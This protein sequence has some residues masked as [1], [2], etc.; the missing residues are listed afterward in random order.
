MEN[1]YIQYMNKIINNTIVIK[2]IHSSYLLSLLQQYIKEKRNTTTTPTIKVS[3]YFNEIKIVLQFNIDY[4]AKYDE[5]IIEI[6]KLLKDNIS[7]IE[8]DIYNTITARKS[9]V[10]TILNLKDKLS[11]INETIPINIIID[12]NVDD[13]N[14]SDSSDDDNSSSSSS[15][16]ED[17]GDIYEINTEERINRDY[18][19]SFHNKVNHHYKERVLNFNVYENDEDDYYKITDRLKSRDSFKFYHYDD[20]DVDI[21]YGVKKIRPS[22]YLDPP[23][24]VIYLDYPYIDDFGNLP[25]RLKFLSL[26]TSLNQKLDLGTPSSLSHLEIR[27]LNHWLTYKGTLSRSITHLRLNCDYIIRSI[28]NKMTKPLFLIPTSV[29]CISIDY[30]YIHFFKMVDEIEYFNGY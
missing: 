19:N 13:D 22:Q 28:E 25:P 11:K 10:T 3:D 8:I 15:G 5:Y 4:K 27:E 14:H 16:S 2:D 7:F 24:S 9:I 20:K 29:Q 6:I 18:H 26:G 23:D 17:E 21:P 30:K 12:D 1:E